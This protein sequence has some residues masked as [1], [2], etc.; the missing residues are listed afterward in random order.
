MARE[1]GL[2]FTPLGYETCDL[3]I[4]EELAGDEAVARLIQAA[5]SPEF[6]EHLQSLKR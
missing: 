6:Q 2:R 3:L 4:R 1:A 5:R